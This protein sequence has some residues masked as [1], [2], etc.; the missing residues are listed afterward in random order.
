M[1][2]RPGATQRRPSG[3][4]E[5]CIPTP[6]GGAS[7]ERTGLTTSSV[8]ALGLIVR[9]KDAGFGCLPA[10]ATTGSPPSKAWLKIKNPSA[11]GVLRFKDEAEP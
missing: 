1:L 7:A 6:A 4:I 9:K 2:F 5:P 10:A 3:Y 8:T 11:P